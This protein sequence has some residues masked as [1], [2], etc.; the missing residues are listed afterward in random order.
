MAQDVQA[1]A[2]RANAE[3]VIFLDAERFAPKAPVS[4]RYRGFLVGP[5]VVSDAVRPCLPLTR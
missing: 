1:E 3:A 5:G 2:R 4:T